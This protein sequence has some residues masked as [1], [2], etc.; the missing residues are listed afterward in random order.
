MT[1]HEVHRAAVKW[2]SRFFNLTAV[3]NRTG[4]HAKGADGARY[5]IHGRQRHEW[6]GASGYHTEF[7]LPSDK[8][9]EWAVLVEFDESDRVEAACK[10]SRADVRRI[11]KTYANHTTK[12]SILPM[13]RPDHAAQLKGKMIYP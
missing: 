12:V 6:Q 9:F 4:Y 8:P 11:G 3:S 7:T 2:A 10:L 13:L 1:R 5:R